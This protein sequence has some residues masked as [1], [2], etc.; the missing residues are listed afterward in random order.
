LGF[1]EL[2]YAPL[3]RYVE[4]CDLILAV[5]VSANL[6][7]LGPRVVQIDVDP[8]APA[9]SGA[10]AG[11]IG[12]ARTV[13]ADLLAAM[14]D[15]APAR[16]HAAVAA[17]VA[18]LRAARFDPAR[19]LQPQWSLMNA[20]RAALPDDAVLVQGMNQMGYYSRNYF[21]TYGPR[22][23]LTSSSLATLGAA[24]P[25]ALGAKLA[26]PQRPVVALC[27]DGGFL[28]NAQ[29]L[30][31]AVQ[32]DIPAI[33]VVFNDNAYGNVLRAQQEEFDG[34]VLGTVLQNPDFVQLAR[35]FGVCGLRAENA[36]EL[37]AALR[38]AVRDGQPTLIEVP[39]GPMQR[40]F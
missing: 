14:H 32:H 21:P 9:A 20:V 5:G 34:H 2:R 27:G 4:G 10:T 38:L 12:D 3:R 7:K 40:E 23:Y 6:S 35:S 22:S 8:E 19:Q 28:Y 17:E 1:G 15:L 18:A 31:T 24:F 36:D 30:A 29:E 26:A 13:L 33:V 11:L 16:S 37:E 39:V 25:L